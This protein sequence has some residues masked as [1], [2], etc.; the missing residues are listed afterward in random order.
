MLESEAVRLGV[1]LAVCFQHII[2]TKAYHY[3]AHVIGS[4]VVSS[5]YR[6]RKIAC[7]RVSK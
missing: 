7:T 1:W 6:M 3:Q 5:M 2:N 4:V